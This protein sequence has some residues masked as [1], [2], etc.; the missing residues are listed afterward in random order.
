M[1]RALTP[2]NGADERPTGSDGGAVRSSSPA[3]G[4]PFGGGS[5]NQTRWPTPLEADG[6]APVLMK[7]LG[8]DDLFLARQA[9][10]LLF[11]GRALQQSGYEIEAFQQ[12]LEGV[13]VPFVMKNSKGL[14]AAVYTYSEPWD[15][16][17]VTAL[18]AWV[19]ALRQAGVG[20]HVPVI[21]VSQTDS[22]EV[23]AL[24]SIFQFIHLP[25]QNLPGE[26]P[27]EP[28]TAKAEAGTPR[29][30]GRWLTNSCS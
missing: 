28:Q 10:Y 1:A 5:L 22:A 27:K 17:A 21:V 23:S 30:P 18:S 24:A 6:T 20:T 26:R 4:G 15:S 2:N 14:P 29:K 7:I 9:A 13:V 8:S 11:A 3:F 16:A 25:Q 12:P 19:T